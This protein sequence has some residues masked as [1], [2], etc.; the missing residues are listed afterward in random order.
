MLKV[1]GQV[2]TKLG[3]EPKFWI[4]PLVFF[5]PDSW[6]PSVLHESS[7][8][9]ESSALHSWTECRAW[10]GGKAHVILGPSSKFQLY[11]LLWDDTRVCYTI[12]H[13]IICNALYSLIRV[14]CI[15]YLICYVCTAESS[16][17]YPRA[18]WNRSEVF[19]LLEQNPPFRWNFTSL[20]V[21]I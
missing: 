6:F 17:Q 21:S 7:A 2:S 18:V 5:L 1:T 8:Y 20:S 15:S 13:S 4:P 16:I 12:L 14:I 3:L 9:H 10:E 19:R 11:S